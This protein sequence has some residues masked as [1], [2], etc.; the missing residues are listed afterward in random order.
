MGTMLYCKVIPKYGGDTNFASMT[1]IFD[2]LSD[3]LQ[4]FL[5]GLEAVHDLGPFKDLFPDTAEGRKK[6]FHAQ[7]KF[8]PVTHPIIRVHSVSGKKILFVNPQFTTHIKGMADDESLAILNML[9]AKTLSHEYHYRHKWKENMLVFWDNSELCLFD[10]YEETVVTNQSEKNLEKRRLL[11][12]LCF[13]KKISFF[14]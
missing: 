10:P 4:N 13:V 9:F 2:S 12:G 11:Y 14:S 7:E 5:S 1:G 8:Q 6:K 3:R